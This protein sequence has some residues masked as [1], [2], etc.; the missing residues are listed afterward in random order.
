MPRV[1]LTEDDVA[2]LKNLIQQVRSGRVNPVN[3]PPRFA[4]Q[5]VVHQAPDVYV[6]LVPRGGI[7]ALKVGGAGTGSG[8]FGPG[9]SPGYA[10]CDIYQIIKAKN[11]GSGTPAIDEPHTLA[12]VPVPGMARVETGGDAPVRLGELVAIDRV[13]EVVGEVGVQRQL[14]ADDPGTHL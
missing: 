6:A 10:W 12:Q 9:D 7:P 3:R 8:S 5:S 2:V 13:V 14:V 4:K 11:A 1:S